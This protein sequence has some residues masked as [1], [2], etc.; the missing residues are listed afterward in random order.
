MGRLFMEL[1]LSFQGTDTTRP[2]KEA[3]RLRCPRRSELPSS[4]MHWARR[5]R[6]RSGCL[7]REVAKMAAIFASWLGPIQ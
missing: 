2:R 6:R 5:S 4:P 1:R 3:G 7:V